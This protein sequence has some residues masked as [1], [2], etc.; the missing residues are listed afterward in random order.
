MSGGE[1]RH[2][3]YQTS[4]E[5]D[6]KLLTQCMKWR[7]QAL[8]KDRTVQ[9][10][11]QSLARAGCT[12]PTERVWC[13]HCS[14]SL[15]GGYRPDGSVTLCSNNV[16]S[17]KHVAETMVHELIHA[18]DDCRAHIEWNN[19]EHLACSEVRAAALSGDCRFLNEIQRGNI[20]IAGQFKRCVRRRAE[21]SIKM[22]PACKATTTVATVDKVFNACLK[23]TEPF[24]RIP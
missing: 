18:F 21:L 19:C 24:E 4:P 11:F 12:M 9:F 2:K 1:E 10:M 15:S 23:D 13:E 5:G 22:S 20:S 3:V 8:R 6:E 7:D 14:P 16:F 17:Q